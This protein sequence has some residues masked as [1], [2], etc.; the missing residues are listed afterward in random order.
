MASILCIDG[1]YLLHRGRSGFKLGPAPVIFNFMRTFRALVE[2]FNPT[3]IYFVLEGHPQQRIDAMP[4]YKANRDVEAG[5]PEA[6]ELETFYDQVDVIVAYLK[7]HFPVSV[8]RHPDYECDDTI[9][10][11]VKRSSTSVEW[12]IVSGDSDF[13]Q[14]LNERMNVKI[15]NPVKKEFVQRPPYDYVTWKALRGDSTDNIPGIPGI[16]DVK[17]TQ[18]MDS[19][20][21]LQEVLDRKDWSE[22]FERNYNLI[23]FY[24]WDDI[25]AFKMTSSTPERNWDVVKSLFERHG[26]NSITKPEAWEKFVST[27]DRLF[28]NEMIP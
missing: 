10:N 7:A 4:S 5:T 23:K 9:A 15:Y 22:I 16:G 11:L 24:E 26:F 21:L 17:A 20:E 12:T 6:K 13:T 2:K 27:F 25:E 8:V 1:M 18:M 19:P 28:G 3:R 14:L